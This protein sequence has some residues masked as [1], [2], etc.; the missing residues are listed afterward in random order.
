MTLQTLRLTALAGFLF[1]VTRLA[2]P[3]ALAAAFAVA[4]GVAL[5]GVAVWAAGP[6]VSAHAFRV[7]TALSHR[8]GALRPS[9][10]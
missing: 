2:D 6:P 7:W 4:A 1:A 3:A 5:V 10:S 9:A 8:T